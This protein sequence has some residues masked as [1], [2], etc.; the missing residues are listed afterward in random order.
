M[1]TLTFT[2]NIQITDDY[3]NL[4]ALIFCQSTKSHPFNIV[5][6][7]KVEILNGTLIH[8]YSKDNWSAD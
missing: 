4:T 2:S 7:E 6:E 5:T 1:R 8:L 3:K